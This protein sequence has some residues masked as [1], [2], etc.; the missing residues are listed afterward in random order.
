M[1]PDATAGP[2][3]RV[4]EVTL[5]DAGR[6]LRARAE[7]IPPAVVAALGMP[8]D[9]LLAL[10]TALTRVIEMTRLDTAEA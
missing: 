6:A 1:I 3:E 2:R 5:T 8:M 4:L 9:E 10:H 7:R